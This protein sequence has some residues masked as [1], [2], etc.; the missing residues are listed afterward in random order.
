MVSGAL[1]LALSAG[2]GSGGLTS[3]A[4]AVAAI[5]VATDA[6]DAALECA[7][8]GRGLFSGVAVIEAEEANAFCQE[9]LTAGRVSLSVECT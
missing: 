2:G 4:A 7:A 6:G 9:D 8:A 3:G 5:L 1:W